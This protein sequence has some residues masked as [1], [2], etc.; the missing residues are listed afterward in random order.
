VFENRVLRRIFGPKR[1]EMT[2]EWRKLHN[3]ELHN[4][5]SSPDIT[6]QV[7]SR[8]MRWVGHVARMGEERKVYKVLVGKSEGRRPL[9]RPRRRWE[10]G[11]RTH[12]TETGLGGVDW[13]RLSQD[14]DRW[15]AVVSA[16]MNLRVPVPRSYLIDDLCQHVMIS[17][18]YN[19]HTLKVFLSSR[20]LIRF[21]GLMSQVRSYA[22]SNFSIADI[23]RQQVAKHPDKVCFIFENTEW[24]FAQVRRVVN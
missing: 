22:R 13:I 12:L 21:I 19:Y 23:F 15:R 20:A 7:K 4:L 24:T 6:R 17:T 8:R 2:G 11:V 3:E 1:D 10:D 18:E 9:G 5:Y 14:R 16:V